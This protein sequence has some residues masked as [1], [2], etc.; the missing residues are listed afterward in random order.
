[1]RT[2]ATLCL[3]ALLSGCDAGTPERTTPTYERCEEDQ[4]LAMATFD[5][6]DDATY[7][8]VNVD[9]VLSPEAR[10]RLDEIVAEE[11]ESR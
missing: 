10:A 6:P 8:C 3:L 2:A 9:D 1:M 11:R 7:V 4:F 5:G